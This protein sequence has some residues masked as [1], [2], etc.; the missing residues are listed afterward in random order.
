MKNYLQIHTSVTVSDA[1]HVVAYVSK[2]SKLMRQGRK[3]CG[4]NIMVILFSSI[5]FSEFLFFLS[6]KIRH[7]AACCALL[8][9]DLILTNEVA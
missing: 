1:H 8:Q 4:M 9:L 5:S 6:N 2:A 7:V 3:I